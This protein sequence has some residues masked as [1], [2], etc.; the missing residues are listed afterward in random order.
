M[1]RSRPLPDRC[2]GIL[3]TLFGRR[4]DHRWLSV[5]QLVAQT[6]HDALFSTF[7]NPCDSTLSNEEKKSTALALHY[8]ASLYSMSDDIAL[9]KSRS[10]GDQSQIHISI[11]RPYMYGLRLVEIYDR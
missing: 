2:G 1:F 8:A 11:Q 5:V 7:A 10:K 9:P 4:K 6:P 3:R